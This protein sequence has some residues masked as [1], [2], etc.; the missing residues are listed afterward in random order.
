MHSFMDL[1]YNRN[2]QVE[3][4]QNGIKIGS[5]RKCKITDIN[6][7]Y[8]YIKLSDEFHNKKIYFGKTISFCITD[9]TSHKSVHD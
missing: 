9:S 8:N 7:D 4:Y 1:S 3:I 2:Y 5:Y 6:L